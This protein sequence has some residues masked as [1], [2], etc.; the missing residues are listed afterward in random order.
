MPANDDEAGVTARRTDLR[1]AERLV[2]I[3]GN[4]IRYVGER[5]DWIT[6]E[7]SRWQ[8]NTARVARCAID[9]SR[10][11]MA[12]ALTMMKVAGDALAKAS[13]SGDVDAKER[14]KRAAD[15][16]R[17]D[18]EWAATS[19]SNTRLRAM[20][21]VAKDFASIRV[22]VDALDADPMLLNAVN[23]TI[24]LR[25]GRLRSHRRSD[26]ITKICPVTYEQA[27]RSNLWERTLRDALGDDETVAYFQ[28]SAGYSCTG[29]TDEEKLF[30]PH[31]PGGGGKSTLIQAIIGAL[32]DYARTADF[33]TFLVQKHAGGP[34]NDVARLAGSRFVASIEVE[35]GKRLAQGLVKQLTGGDVVTAR[36]LYSEAFE[37][38]PQM[39]L[40]LVV[41]DLP[42][43]S[44]DDSGM[45]RRIE[46]IP[47]EHVVPKEKRN[48]A[49]KKELCDVR[50]SGPAVLAWL[51]QGALAW[52]MVGLR[53]P[54]RIVDAT[55]EYRATEDHF[56]QFVAECCTHPSTSSCTRRDLRSA[57]DGWYGARGPLSQKAFNEKV[58]E[59]AGITE[60]TIHGVRWW[61]GVALR[62]DLPGVL[63]AARGAVSANLSH[64][65][66]PSEGLYGNEPSTCTLHPEDEGHAFSDLLE[67]SAQ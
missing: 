55:R 2:E 50:I 46:R 13:A 22:S 17:R 52:Q 20:L 54:S 64:V 14:A 8:W 27:A 28:R 3:H 48:P 57:Y 62:T 60:K 11:M 39:K 21:D 30:V 24:D 53:T 42:H 5:R 59:L 31:G 35:Q 12:D 19:Q 9:V 41:N 65:R 10:R 1:N 66:D 34:K 26:L 15:E 56:A 23:G 58:R 25:T 6:W 47:F 40:W 32:G 61:V 44:A 43:V 49:V 16:A 18:L 67:E 4:E 63:G 7:E 33:E 36:F 38:K 37:F 29:L 51:V 45:W